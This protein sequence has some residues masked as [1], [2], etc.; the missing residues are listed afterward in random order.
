MEERVLRLRKVPNSRA[1]NKRTIGED[2]E[3]GLL[4]PKA[5]QRKR[6]FW[7]FLS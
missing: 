4:N 5:I 2:F 3:K 7:D 1:I 6:R